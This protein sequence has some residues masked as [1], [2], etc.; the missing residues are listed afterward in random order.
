MENQPSHSLPFVWQVNL[1]DVELSVHRNPQ[2]QPRVTRIVVRLATTF[3]L[4][5]VNGSRTER[6]KVN[7]QQ[8]VNIGRLVIEAI[9]ADCI[10][11]MC[12]S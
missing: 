5:R 9:V 11:G 8:N 4:N 1:A 10:N 3:V 7:S 12:C 6:M 2:P